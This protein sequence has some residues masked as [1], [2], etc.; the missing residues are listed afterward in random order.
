[1]ENVRFCCHCNNRRFD[2][3]NMVSVYITKEYIA[4][5]YHHE[6]DTCY[7]KFATVA[8]WKCIRETFMHP[9][10][11]L[12]RQPHKKKKRRKKMEEEVSYDC[13]IFVSI[14][15]CVMLWLSSNHMQL[16]TYFKTYI[17][18]IVILLFLLCMTLQVESM[19][20]FK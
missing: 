18:L 17:S 1:M 15:V 4:N 6:C 11:H 10:P 8:D 12:H 2:K 7:N 19:L 13:L 16:H 9:H 14:I 20:F 5:K 3:I